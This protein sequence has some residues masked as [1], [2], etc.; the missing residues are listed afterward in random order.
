M[1]LPSPQPSPIGMGE[2]VFRRR[3]LNIVLCFLTLA[4][5]AGEG[6][7]EGTLSAERLISEIP[8][9]FFGVPLCRR[10]AS[11]CAYGKLQEPI[12]LPTAAS[13]RVTAAQVQLS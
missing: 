13:T 10:L 5:C 11:A 12:R 8:D 1:K 9:F 4:R 3:P 6:K 2:G 7:G